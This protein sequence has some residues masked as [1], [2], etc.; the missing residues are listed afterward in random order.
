MEIVVIGHLSRDLIITSDESKETLGGGP[1]YAAIA[2]SIG[3]LGAGVV[4]CVGQ[5]FEKE[6][7]DVLQG[8][9]L[10]ISAIHVKGPHSTRFVNKYDE[11]GVRSQRVESVAPQIS[12]EDIL[13]Q[14]M[15]ASIYHFCPLTAEE[16]S[17]EVIEAVQIGN[18]LISIDVQGYLRDI[19]SGKVV[20]R[21]W[22]NRD[23]ILSLAD[24]VKFD[25]DELMLAYDVKT[26]MS[27]ITEIM[28]LGPRMVL[29][30]RERKGSTVYTRN[31][32]E[33]IPLVLSNAQVD[34]T[35]CGDTY[36]IGFLL[37]YMRTADVKRAGLFGATCS[38][39]NVEHMGPYEM[40]SREQVERRMK[41]Y[42]Q[43]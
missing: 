3:A 26:E 4:S 43:A 30:T 20:P 35:G 11:A 15:G 22:D 37:E 14:Y 10:N 18:P 23:E 41:P 42:V 32:Q 24:V 31:I 39:F 16:I 1:A 21:T 17:I 29:I 34:S 27:A 40:P 2:P 8:S 36:T 19:K 13:P 9:G 7:F 25:E 38:S 33:D 5:D 12:P 6:Y 28:N